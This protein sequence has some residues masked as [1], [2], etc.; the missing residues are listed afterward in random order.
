MIQI[1]VRALRSPVLNL[2]VVVGSG[3]HI[4]LLLKHFAKLGKLV[5]APLIAEGFHVVEFPCSGVC[6]LDLPP[7]VGGYDVRSV[8]KLELLEELILSI[9]QFPY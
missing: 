9:A 7:F 8:F 3:L 2:V 1:V 4:L 5:D 6:V